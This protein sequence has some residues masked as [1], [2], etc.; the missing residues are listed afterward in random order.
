MSL[1]ELR[2]LLAPHLLGIAAATATFTVVRLLL[3]AESPNLLAVPDG[4]AWSV[5]G[6]VAPMSLTLLT[7]GAYAA[8]LAT[9]RRLVGRVQTSLRLLGVRSL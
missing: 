5:S 6:L 2:R 4:G 8:A 9:D 3:T 7:L 1:H